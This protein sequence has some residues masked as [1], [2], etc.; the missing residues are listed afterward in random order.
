LERLKDVDESIAYLNAA[1]EESDEDFLIAL[2]DV[3]EAHGIASIASSAGVRRE[4]VY[5]MLSGSGNPTFSNLTG[6]LKAIGMSIAVKSDMAQAET[7]TA[8]FGSMT[9]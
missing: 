4:S 5:R 3:A 1:L 2:R 7:G 9:R 8:P 6:I